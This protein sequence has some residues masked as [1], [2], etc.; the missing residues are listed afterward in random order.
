MNA[1]PKIGLAERVRSLSPK[2]KQY[3]VLGSLATVFL[4][5]VFGSV[6]VWD[7]QPALTPQTG[8]EE[9]KSKNIATPVLRSI[10]AM[11]GWRSRR[12]S[13]RRWMRS[14]RD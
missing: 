9:L 11:S 1:T 8:K 7:N 12:S 14:F 6:A 10:H 2:A 5:L 13:R 4:G 3:L